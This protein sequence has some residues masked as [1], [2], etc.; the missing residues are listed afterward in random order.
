M[1][2]FDDFARTDA[3]P[4]QFCETSYAFL[5]RADWPDVEAIRTALNAWFAKYPASEQRK[6][7]NNFMSPIYS[8]HFGAWWELYVFTLYRTLGYDLIV[9][10]DVPATNNDR[11]PDFLVTADRT[12]FY[13]ECTAVSPKSHSGEGGGPAWLY[14]AINE[15]NDPNFY[16]G[17]RIDQSGTEQPRVKDVTLP[18]AS[19]LSGLDPDNVN[20]AIP[21]LELQAKD[22]KLNVTA[23]LIAP[24]KRNGTGRLLGI[25]PPS[26]AFFLNDIDVLHDALRDK[27]S[28]YGKT[29][30][31]P[32]IV[33]LAS[34]TGFTDDEDVT[35]AVFGRKALQIVEAQ[36]SSAKLVRL[37]NGY[38]RP[39]TGDSPARGARV[40]GVLFG[41]QLNPWSAGRAFPKLW[42]NPWAHHSQTA[43]DSFTVVRLNDEGDIVERPGTGGASILGLQ[44]SWPS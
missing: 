2:L 43:T 23:Y 26:G 17:L 31:K 28:R 16:V 34:A 21:S 1:K 10:P 8:I 22:W 6:L 44:A 25:L 20:E 42:L 19:W 14:D 24:E 40:S 11:T 41:Q 38:W 33:A 27:G 12:S 3:S 4:A 39:A 18:I 15:V 13:V 7:R 35:D 36:S 37:G 30:D 29:L 32:F 5:N 9:H